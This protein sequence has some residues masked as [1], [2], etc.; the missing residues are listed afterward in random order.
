MVFKTHLLKDSVI[1]GLMTEPQNYTHD[2]NTM[3]KNTGAQSLNDADRAIIA[4]Y[5]FHQSKK[6]HCRDCIISTMQNI[7]GLP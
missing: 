5:V 2:Y 7:H 1:N 4:A 3:S 6:Y